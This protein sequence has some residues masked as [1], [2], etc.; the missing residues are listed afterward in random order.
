MHPCFPL[1]REISVTEYWTDIFLFKKNQIKIVLYSYWIRT[2][3]WYRLFGK[4]KNVR[5]Q[6]N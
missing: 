4:S 3:F 6:W 5:C 2:S 1:Q